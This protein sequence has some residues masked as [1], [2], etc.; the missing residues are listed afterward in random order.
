MVN[1]VKHPILF[2]G[3]YGIVFMFSVLDNTN[4]LT[5]E[6]S[7]N[8]KQLYSSILAV[9]GLKQ[10][11]DFA[12]GFRSFGNESIPYILNL[13]DDQNYWNRIAGIKGSEFF[14]NQD[15]NSKILQLYK[16]DHMTNSESKE[17]LVSRYI[18]LETIILNQIE[19][20]KDAGVQKKLLGLV[21]LPIPNE[22]KL[23]LISKIKDLKFANRVEIHSIL[24]SEIKLGK[25]AKEDQ[26]FL[27]SFLDDPILRIP[28]LEFIEETGSNEDLNIFLDIIKETSSSYTEIG[29][30][31]RAMQKWGS[32]SIQKSNYETL[33]QNAKEDRTKYMS[34]LLFFNIKSESLRLSLCKIATSHSAQEMRLVAA[35]SLVYYDSATNI[36]CLERMATEKIESA[37]NPTLGDLAIG[38]LTF[39]ISGFKKARDESNRRI[40]FAERQTTINS[41]LNYLRKKE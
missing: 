28:T 17:F 1:R 18:E 29:P 4:T 27:R 37:P 11:E 30:S 35:L 36:P 12:K 34:M 5:A 14:R 25:S 39:G 23:F 20:E 15:L 9:S 21:P 33:L 6:T 41:H 10:K 3:L 32:I 19:N 7:K 31:L 38:I 26:L 13:L 16:R 40:H 8:P 22:S 24:K 2:F